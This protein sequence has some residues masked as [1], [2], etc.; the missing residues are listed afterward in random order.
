MTLMHQRGVNMKIRYIPAS[1]TLL[2]GAVASLICLMK[3]YD[4]TYSL[5]VLLVTLIIFACIGF[6]AQKVIINVMHEQKVQEEERIRM[7]EWKETER[8]RK[9]EE[10]KAAMEE[11]EDNAEEE[12]VEDNQE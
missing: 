8:L 5:E 9:L 11:L 12:N 10:E 2:A 6:E 3:N 1:V 7:A 4:V